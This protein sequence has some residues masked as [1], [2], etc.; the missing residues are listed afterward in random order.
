MQIS[1]SQKAQR[2]RQALLI[3]EQKVA[4]TIRTD[5]DF[6]NKNPHLISLLSL[7]QERDDFDIDSE[8]EIVKPVKEDN[9][10]TGVAKDIENFTKQQEVTSSEADLCMERLGN[11]RNLVLESV[12]KRWIKSGR[13]GSTASQLST[14]SKRDRTGENLAEKNSRSRVSSPPGLGQ[15]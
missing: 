4:E 7:F 14:S 1:H 6:L 13:R 12:K 15:I 10:L 8:K 9:F 11:V 3:T 2:Y 5:P